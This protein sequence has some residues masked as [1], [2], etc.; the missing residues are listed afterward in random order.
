MVYENPAKSTIIRKIS[1]HMLIALRKSRQE[2]Y[3]N[4]F[5]DNLNESLKNKSEEMARQKASGK[6]PKRDVESAS[7]KITFGVDKVKEFPE[8]YDRAIEVGD[9]VDARYSVKGMYI[10]RP[11]GFRALRS[12][13]EIMQEIMDRTGHDE[14]YFPM[15]IPESIFGKER[16]FL[17]GFK[18]EAFVVTKA[19]ND[20]LTESLYIRPTSETGIYENV[21]PWIRSV[22]DLPLRLYQIVNIFRYETKQTR[23]LLRLRE[24]VKFKEAHTFHATAEDA[25]A[26]IQV[27]VDAYKE[28]FD[29]LLIPNVVVKT[30]S[31]DIFAGAVYNM[32]LMSVMPDGKAIELASVIN[33]G[34]KFAKVYNLTYQSNDNK[35][36]YVHQTCYG[37]S[38]RGLGV[39]LAIHG[40]NRGLIMPPVIA[41]IHVVVIPIF[42]KGKEEE[43]TLRAIEA[44][45][46]IEKRGFR[47][48]LDTRDRGVGDKFYEWEAKGIPVRVE[49]GPKEIENG[50]L[51][52]FRRDTLKKETVKNADAQARITALMDEITETLRTRAQEYFKGRVIHFDTAEEVKKKYTERLGLVGLPWCGDEKC[53]RKLEEVIGIPTIG[54]VPEKHL[55][56]EC[57]SC[58]KTDNVVEMFFGRTY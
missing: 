7:K 30:P 20:D 14:V 40:D 16:D 22:S 50:E 8:W 9:I 42:K 24:V 2:I 3:T 46:M 27:G 52:L 53:G 37:I 6:V 29:K 43:I 19:G 25:D 31:W 28:F 4:V 10:W 57:A 38:E 44:K 32:D 17:K 21:R 35:Q 48:T 15:L 39:L 11:Y 18:G 26:Q 41:P 12:M 51:V 54:F 13:M 56:K 45:K 49:I 1:I 47:V 55:N 36:E 23:P 34:T 33:L 58:G 5:R